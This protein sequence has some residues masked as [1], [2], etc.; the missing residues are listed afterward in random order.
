MGHNIEE[1]MRFWLH[2]ELIS[3]EALKPPI[4]PKG[5]LDSTW[6]LS[7]KCIENVIQKFRR[8]SYLDAN[9]KISTELLLKSLSCL[10]SKQSPFNVENLSHNNSIL[11]WQQQQCFCHKNSK[12][13]GCYKTAD[14]DPFICII[15]TQ[16]M[17]NFVRN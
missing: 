5:F 10:E 14:C 1:I 8:N 2:P 7:E 12:E 11:F 4:K 15:Q 13:K 17:H 16:K 3:I 6:H 9:D